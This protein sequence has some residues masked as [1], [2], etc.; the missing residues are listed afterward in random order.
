[1]DKPL[2]QRSSS[3]RLEKLTRLGGRLTAKLSKLLLHSE[4]PQMHPG[5]PT[6]RIVV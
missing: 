4:T 3:R 2:R 5:T 6:R 1:M